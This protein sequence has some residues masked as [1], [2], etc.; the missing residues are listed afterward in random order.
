MNEYPVLS[1]FCY[2]AEE[3]HDEYGLSMDGILP[4]DLGDDDLPDE[5]WFSVFKNRYQKKEKIYPHHLQP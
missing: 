5:H 2:T 3:L 4:K 1:K